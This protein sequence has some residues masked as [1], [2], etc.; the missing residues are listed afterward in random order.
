[1]LDR[2]SR[3][4]DY[5]P[6]MSNIIYQIKSWRRYPSLVHGYS[7]RVLGDL[8]FRTSPSADVQLRRARLAEALDIEPGSLF[9]IPLGHTNRVVVLHDP[10]FLGY[11]DKRGYLP[12]GQCAIVE[13]PRVSEKGLP[14]AMA[15]YADGVVFDV[16]DAYSLII[17][18]DCATVSF[19]DSDLG[20]CGNAHVGL[21][22]A[23]N[24]LPEAIVQAMST[25][26][27]CR[28]ESIEVVIYPCIRSCHYELNRSN[29]WL[30][31]KE[32]VLAAYGGDNRFYADGYFDLPGFI[33]DQLCKCGVSS[34]NI[35]DTGLCTVCHYDRFFSH[36]GA[37]EPEAQQKEG[38]FGSIIGIR[39]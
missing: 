25:E 2:P 16:R 36:A 23:V 15:A 29:T 6:C 3:R 38:R 26:F 9:S 24:G 30:R 5:A 1:M 12:V 39:S 14:S 20:V 28:P 7:D 18:A 33:I 8:L 32:D 34:S 21:V 4:S 27:G 35:H 37:A 10:G 11:L 13:H 31:I 17:T 22:G 19:Y